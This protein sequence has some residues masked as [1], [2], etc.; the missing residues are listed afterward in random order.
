MVHLL[1]TVV[2]LGAWL[3]EAL[4]RGAHHRSHSGPA[5]LAGNVLLLLLFACG[6][7]RAGDVLGLRLNRY[8]TLHVHHSLHGVHLWLS[9]SNIFCL[10][11]VSLITPIYESLMERF[12]TLL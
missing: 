11:F 9:L 8:L 1:L 6:T 10:V 4:W 5:E 12:K 7:I 2:V 3:G